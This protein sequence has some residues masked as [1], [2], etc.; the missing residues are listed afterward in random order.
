MYN[1][2]VIGAEFGVDDADAAAA[3][4]LGEFYPGR[5]VVSLDVD[6]IGEAAGGIHCATQQQPAA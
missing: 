1:G 5:E 4:I 3:R 6:P 2:A